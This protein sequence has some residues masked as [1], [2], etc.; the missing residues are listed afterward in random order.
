MPYETSIAGSSGGNSAEICSPMKMF[1]YLSS[2]RV[3]LT[4]DLS[5]LHE[6]LNE[7]NA[8]FCPP[9]DP[10]AWSRILQELINDPEKCERL[11]RQ[12]RLDAE[13]YSWKKR[14]ERAIREL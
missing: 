1:D 9:E 10:Q 8:V 12:A 6:I 14:A 5:V 11:S 4:S 13:N 2:G 3:I 7:K